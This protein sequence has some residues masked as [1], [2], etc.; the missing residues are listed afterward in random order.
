MVFQN[1]VKSDQS[2]QAAAY[3]GAHGRYFAFQIVSLTWLYAPDVLPS[4]AGLLSNALNDVQSSWG[5]KN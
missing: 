4:R 1:G 3:N 2:V 5:V